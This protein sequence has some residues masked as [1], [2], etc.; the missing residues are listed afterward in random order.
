MPLIP[1]VLCFL[2]VIPLSVNTS[3]NNEL[4]TLGNASSNL[5]S[6]E[7]ERELGSAW[8]AALRGQVNTYEQPIIE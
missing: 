6:I 3:A 1:S 4:P 2:F 5:I 8:L 7:R